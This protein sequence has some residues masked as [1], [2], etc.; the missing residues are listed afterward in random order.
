MLVNADFIFTYCNEGNKLAISTQRSFRPRKNFN[1]EGT[2]DQKPLIECG[3]QYSCNFAWRRIWDGSSLAVNN[4]GLTCLDRMHVSQLREA[5]KRCENRAR[6][7]S[8]LRES[9]FQ[10]TN[11]RFG[12]IHPVH[13]ATAVDDFKARYFE[14]ATA[15]NQ[16]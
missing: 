16:S 11:N 15:A 8:R 5:R 1:L 9:L 2:A 3:F 7:L 4:V 12:F 13:V 6:V 14:F 10:V